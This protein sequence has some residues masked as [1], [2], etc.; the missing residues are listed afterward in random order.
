MPQRNQHSLSADA[1]FLAG[2]HLLVTTLPAQRWSPA[3]LLELY[4]CRWHIEVL[5]KRIK[6]LLDIHRLRC[7]RPQTAEVLVAAVL[8]GWLLIED[9]AAELRRQITD[10]EPLRVPLSDWHLDQWACAGLKKVI[11]GWWSPK[12]LRALLPELRC[13]FSV[14]RHRPLQ[15]HQRRQ[16]FLGILFPA[17]DRVL[18]FD[19]S[20]A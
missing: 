5:F 19:C 4:R 16:R 9:Q 11:E 10:G 3:L 17:D 1:R 18:M 2:F 7:H 12:Q 20:S 15:E 14:R 8:L 13:L 6:Q